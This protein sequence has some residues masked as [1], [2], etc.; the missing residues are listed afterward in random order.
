MIYKIFREEEWSALQAEG[1][2]DGAPVD[3]S[4]GFIHFSTA[5]QIEETAAKHFAGEEGLWLAAI[6]E[7][8]LGGDLKWEE[9]RGGALFPHLYAKLSFEHI[10]WC[11]PLPLRASGHEFPE[12]LA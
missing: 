4:D 10:L 8:D 12:D 3:V 9:S 5:Q 11:T 1:Q 7:N 6:D 2:T